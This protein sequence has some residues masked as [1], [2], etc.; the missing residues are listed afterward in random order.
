MRLDR[1]GAQPRAALDRPDQ[2]GRGVHLEKS[3]VNAFLLPNAP[4]LR[5][6]GVRRNSKV[7]ISISRAKPLEIGLHAVSTADR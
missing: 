2:S 3:T 6:A 7:E 1:P 5:I 4:Y